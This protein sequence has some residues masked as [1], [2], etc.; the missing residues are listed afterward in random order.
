MAHLLNN[1]LALAVGTIDLLQDDP[2]LSPEVREG[3][4]TT[5]TALGEAAQHLAKFQRVV[6]VATQ[7]TPIGLTLDIDRSI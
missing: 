7:E 3:L 4:Q 6:R 2:T 1:D 5:L